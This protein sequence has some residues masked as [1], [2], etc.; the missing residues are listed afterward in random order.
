[1][2]N[3]QD[4]LLLLKNLTKTTGIV[5]E[6]QTIQLDGWAKVAFNPTETK[7]KYTVG[8]ELENKVVVYKI[9]E[10]ACPYKTVESTQ[11]IH[12]CQWVKWLLGDDWNVKVYRGKKYLGVLIP[13]LPTKKPKTN[14]KTA[15][16][17]RN[18]RS[19]PKANSKRV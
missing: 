5:N 16:R 14:V 4:Q 3:L 1:M 15:N 11:L 8:L 12:L 2:D 6:L 9:A 18:P 17:R 19:S 7:T 13:E 10:K